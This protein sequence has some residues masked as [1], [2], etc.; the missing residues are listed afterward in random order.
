M[1]STHNVTIPARA[2][3][4]FVAFGLVTI[5]GDREIRRDV[6]PLVEAMR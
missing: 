4:C 1:S 5:A 6:T 3:R 2:S